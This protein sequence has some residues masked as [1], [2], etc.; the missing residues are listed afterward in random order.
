MKFEQCS[1]F[2]LMKNAQIKDF[3][4]GLKLG[5][6]HSINKSFKKNALKDY[7]FSFLNILLKLLRILKIFFKIL[8]LLFR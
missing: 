2:L 5:K 7:P 3:I 8:N 1:L 6:K 4:S